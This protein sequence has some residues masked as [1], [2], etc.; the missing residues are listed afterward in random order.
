[1]VIFYGFISI[2][3]TD[4][5]NYLGKNRKWLLGF[6]FRNIITVIRL[7]SLFVLA[8]I[9]IALP[10][11][12][13][14]L[15]RITLLGRMLRYFLRLKISLLAPFKRVFWYYIINSCWRL[16]WFLSVKFVRNSK[17]NCC[18][19]SRFP[20]IL[21]TWF[22]PFFPSSPFLIWIAAIMI[23]WSYTLPAHLRA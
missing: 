16:K 8:F 2:H 10:K 1:M 18:Y 21:W 5:L 22:S 14:V 7:L 13:C 19:K 4:G 11:F 12:L 17:N 20:P 15:Q 9:K 3:C 23:C 6:W